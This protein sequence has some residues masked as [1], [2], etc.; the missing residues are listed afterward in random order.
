M[1]CVYRIVS[2]RVVSCWHGM[3]WYG[4]ASYRITYHANPNTPIQTRANNTA[5]PATNAPFAFLA[6][7]AAPPVAMADGL[8]DVEGVELWGNVSLGNT[9]VVVVLPTVPVLVLVI[10]IVV[11]EAVDWKT[12]V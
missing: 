5:I 8:A 6:I 9:T 11:P 1:A 12:D 2:C 3:A 10:K 4:M 7:L